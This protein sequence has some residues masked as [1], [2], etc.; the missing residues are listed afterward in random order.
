M[1]T[2]N[3]IKCTG[4]VAFLTLGVGCTNLDE[5][6]YDIIIADSFF[7][8]RENVIQAFVRP[9]EHSY[10]STRYTFQ[11]Q[12]G[13]ADHFATYNRQGHW[14]DSQN[15]FRI[16]Y[17]TW[18][19]DDWIPRDIWNHNMQG[20]AYAN[21]AIADMER[22]NAE[23]FGFTQ[24]EIDNF[25]A[26]LRTLRAW[27]YITLLDIFRNVPLTTKYPDPENLFPTQATPQAT[28]DFIED[29]LT[30]VMSS[31]ETKEGVAGNGNKQ[32]QWNKAGAAALLARLYLNAQ[33]WIGTDMYDQC[34][35]ICQDIIEGDYGSYGIAERWDAPFD[36]QNE[37]CEEI[38]YAFTSSYGY[39]HWVYSNETFWW[40]A[41]FKAAPYF[42][43][44]DWGDMNHRWGLQPG[45]DFN[46]NEYT[47]ANGKPVRKFMKYP[48]D[49]RLKKYKNLGNSTREGMFIYGYLDYVDALGAEKRVMADN[50][51]YTIYLRDQV[52]EFVDTPPES[53][54]PA[55]TTEEAVLES[56]MN[57]GDQNSGWCLIKYPIYRSEDAGKMESDYAVI[58]LAEI[59]YMLAE[60]KWRDGDNPAA[61][62]LLNHVRERYYPP[63]SESLYDADEI[64][65]QEMIDEWGREFIGENMR[66]T[67][68]CRFGVFNG[69]WWDKQPDADNHSMILPL[70]R[71]VMNA[72]P[73]LVQNPGYPDAS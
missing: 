24:G 19:I 67:V 43:F 38:I 37:N 5:T 22:I 45:L 14:L 47:F 46:G 28:F 6:V 23:D 36:Y 49:V 65:E 33:L 10:S 71:R 57:N 17:H 59:Y 35:I 20:V 72:N 50:G 58:R 64:N 26:Q 44:S 21:S 73:N 54:K 52:G 62:Q 8:T 1:K 16:H 53:F 13:A 12:E 27:H 48:D 41:P 60:C 3:I 39:S 69:E 4:L 55:P 56:T 32:G 30:D 61:A 7:K 2:M 29:E 51:K 42:G 66:R 68:L 18:T 31:L 25:I 11:I 63:G 15:Y 34:A 9:F 40:G 70:S